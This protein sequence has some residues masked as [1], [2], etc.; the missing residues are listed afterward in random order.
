[1]WMMRKFGCT[2]INIATWRNTWQVREIQDQKAEDTMER[3]MEKER[4]T[5]VNEKEKETATDVDEDIRILS[6]RKVSVKNLLAS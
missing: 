1:M 2:F 4:E 3:E 6:L 5:R